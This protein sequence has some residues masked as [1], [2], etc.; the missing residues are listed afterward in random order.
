MLSPE[1]IAEAARRLIA[2]AAHPAKVI[3]FGSYARGEADEASDLDLMVVEQ[4][5]TDKANEYLRLREAVGHAGVGIDLLLVSAQEFERRSQVPGTAA[6]WAK[7]EGK[8][9][10]DA[11]A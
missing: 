11:A 1:H 3:L 6:Y 10:Y 5:L 7:K 8:I 2:R 4:G 9:L